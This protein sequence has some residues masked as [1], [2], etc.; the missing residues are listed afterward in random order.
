MTRPSFFN[1]DALVGELWNEISTTGFS[2][3]C[4]TDFYDYV[5]YL[6][7]KYDRNHFLDAND[8]TDNERLLKT[9]ASRINSA[10]KN[11]SVQF[12]DGKEYESIFARFIERIGKGDIPKLDDT[13]DS[14]TMVLEDA[15]LRDTLATKLKRVAHTTLDYKLN[16]ELVTVKHEA[17]IAMLASELKLDESISEGIRRL[18]SDTRD[19]LEKEKGKQDMKKALDTALQTLKDSDSLQSL[20]INGLKAVATFVSKKL[21]A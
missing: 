18:I 11:I 15:T 13:G 9:K 2:N 7:N 4:K 21:T 12:M 3:R 8:N 16:K 1:Q 6:L 19:A 20:G 17:F 14:Y 5:L 10:K